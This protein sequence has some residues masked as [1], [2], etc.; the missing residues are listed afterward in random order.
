MSSREIDATRDFLVQLAVCRDFVTLISRTLVGL[1]RSEED[2]FCK[3]LWS[4]SLVRYEGIRK[5]RNCVLVNLVNLS[6]SLKLALRS[7]VFFHTDIFLHEDDTQEFG[8]CVILVFDVTNREF[9]SREEG[10]GIT[11]CSE[12]KISNCT[13]ENCTEK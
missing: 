1:S 13:S 10:F 4:R 9:W 12:R 6:R 5:F 3:I 7:Q 2:S 8:T 11:W